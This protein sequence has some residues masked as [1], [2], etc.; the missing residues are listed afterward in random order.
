MARFTRRSIVIGAVA[1][2][3]LAAIGWSLRPRPVPADFAPVIRGNLT[4]TVD[5][6]GETRLKDVSVVSAP[7]RGRVL[8]IDIEVG[9]GIR[10]GET[11]LAT[12]EPTDPA[13]LDVRSRSEA[14]S[15]VGAAEAAI[16]LA[17]AERERAAAELAF[18]E[19]ELSRK[20]P[21]AERGTI[22]AADLDRTRLEA[23]RARAAVAEARANVRVKRS[24]LDTSKNPLN[25]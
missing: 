15:E 8:R 21:L 24:Q 7:V 17:I 2:L 4:V 6:E 16:Q 3:V 11:V 25:E 20:E 12:F 19:S 23:D 1:L 14:E 13:I 10:A 5:D 18:A 9:D 22:S